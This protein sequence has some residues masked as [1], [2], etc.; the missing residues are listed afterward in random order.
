[1]VNK[2]L[3]AMPHDEGFK[4]MFNGKDLTGWQDL[5]KILLKGKNEAR[6]NLKETG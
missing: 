6:L 2:Y 4:P 5:L 3:A 1:M